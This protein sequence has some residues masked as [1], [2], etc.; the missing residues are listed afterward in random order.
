M[1]PGHPLAR[2]RRLRLADLAGHP[3]DLLGERFHPYQVLA[4]SAAWSTLASQVTLTLNRIEM[5]K[6][7]V[8][9]TSAVTILP[10]DAVAT[11]A[12]D[13]SLAVIDIH[14]CDFPRSHTLRCV[15]RGRRVTSA[16]IRLLDKLR[17]THD[18]VRAQGRGSRT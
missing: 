4:A 2:R 10:D 18:A 16:T 13:G 11:E 15:R 14:L 8:Q 9:A 12:Q 5:L 3:L 1:A 6:G 7:H 17:H